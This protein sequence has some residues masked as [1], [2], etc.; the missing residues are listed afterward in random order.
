[1]DTSARRAT[2]WQRAPPRR[3]LRQVARYTGE[4]GR[5]AVESLSWRLLYDIRSPVPVT[6]SRQGAVDAQRS[7]AA[8]VAE[9]IARMPLP[10]T[11]LREYGIRGVVG[12]DLDAEGAEVIARAYGTYLADH[13]VR[14]AVI[15][16]D[17]RTSS[18]TLYDAA[19]RGL[20]GSGCDVIKIGLCVT[21]MLYF[22]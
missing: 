12:P 7:K 9:R 14:R 6:S 1:R 22:A 18:H 4:R 15:G 2:R 11:I 5:Q 19:V 10:Q 20:T 21:P 17:N 3:D 13:G 8:P 16:H